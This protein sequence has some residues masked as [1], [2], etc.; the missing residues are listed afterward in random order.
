MGVGEQLKATIKY[1][2]LAV[3]RIYNYLLLYYCGRV[4]PLAQ[5]RRGMETLIRKYRR[6]VIREEPVDISDEGYVLV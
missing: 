1:I 4:F 5:I 3:H 2:S 6:Q